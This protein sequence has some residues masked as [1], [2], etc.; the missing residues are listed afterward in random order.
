MTSPDP[1]LLAMLRSIWPGH[2]DFSLE[3]RLAGAETMWGSI[4]AWHRAQLAAAR[5]AEWNAAI[6]VAAIRV[7]AGGVLTDAGW[8][9]LPGEI[10]AL[11]RSA[12][13]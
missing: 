4:F 13:P 1:E 2:S 12:T 10:R 7:E 5:D 8:L 3:R 11:K 6:E 9:I